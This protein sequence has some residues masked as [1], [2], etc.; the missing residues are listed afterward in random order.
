MIGLKRSGPNN[1]V[2]V[3]VH[4]VASNRHSHRDPLLSE[5]QLIGLICFG[6]LRGKLKGV[7]SNA[8]SIVTEPE[9]QVITNREG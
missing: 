4:E 1:F 7:G 8:I 2:V 5:I 3:L 6:G 9:F